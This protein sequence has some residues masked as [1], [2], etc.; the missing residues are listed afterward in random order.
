MDTHKNAPLTPKGREAM[1]RSVIE[2]RLTKAAAA[3]Q[4]NTTAKTVANGSNASAL[5]VS[6]DCEI[7]P[8]ALI[9]RQTKLCLPRARRS[10][11]CAGSATR[12]SK[13][14][15][16]PVCRRQPSAASCAGWD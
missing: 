16:K 9:P 7:V 14:L 1:V 2:G 6:M 15:P 10:R 5:K 4:F 3:R 12:A 8:R 13:S 11:P